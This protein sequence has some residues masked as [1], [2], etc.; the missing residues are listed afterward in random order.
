[1]YR[2]KIIVKDL[3]L[4]RMLDD[5]INEIDT[6]TWVFPC[7]DKSNRKDEKWYIKLV[8]LQGIV[9]YSKGYKTEVLANKAYDK[10]TKVKL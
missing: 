6:D 10:L 4:N 8:S 9:K 7:Q 3:N 1:M 5:V 2:P